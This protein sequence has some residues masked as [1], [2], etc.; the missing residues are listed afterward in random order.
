VRDQRTP[1]GSPIPLSALAMPALPPF[2]NTSFIRAE[3][4]YI[5][6]PGRPCLCARCGQVIDG[7]RGVQALDGMHVSVFHSDCWTGD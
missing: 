1:I 5:L 3:G 2:D 7:G 4:G 6:G